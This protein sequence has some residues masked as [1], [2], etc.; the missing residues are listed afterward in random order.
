MGVYSFLVTDLDKYLPC[1]DNNNASNEYYL[2]QIFEFIPET[3][4]YRVPQKDYI[5]LKGVNTPEEL[6]EIS[7][8]NE[9][10]RARKI[11]E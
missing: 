1:L 8:L 4:V 5:Y 7:L 9:S 6:K 11:I 2:T 3:I 10:I